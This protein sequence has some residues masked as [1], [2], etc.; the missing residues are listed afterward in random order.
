MKKYLVAICLIFN[1]LIIYCQT[2][3]GI[4]H[5]FGTKEA[6][7]Y[8]SIGIRNKA[9]GTISNQEGRF[10]LNLAQASNKDTLIIS[11][12]GYYS[13]LISVVELNDKQ[14]YSFE[15]KPNQQLLK[16]VVIS[17]KLNSIILGNKGKSSQFTGWGDFTSS[18][19]RAVGLLINHPARPAKIN[20]VFFHVNCQFDSARIRVNLFK[21]I[22]NK[23]EP[24]ESQKQN[25]FLTIKKTNGWIEVPINETIELRK[26]D[27][28]VAIEWV[29]A[30]AKFRTMKEGG[31]YI[32]SLSLTN[33]PGYFYLRQTPEEK[34]QLFQAKFT[35]S[36]Y[37]DCIPI[38]D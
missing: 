31:S 21:L 23:I 18:R 37:L 9:I 5:D 26:D 29:D 33:S 32:F 24:F 6:L 13:I 7:P 16:E 11:Y 14:D 2:I 38:K 10:Q 25:I 34:V 30:W 27:I 17:A 15:L 36:I 1:S 19:G 8:V 20:K 35:P 3:H 22:E 28:I 4:I 12:I